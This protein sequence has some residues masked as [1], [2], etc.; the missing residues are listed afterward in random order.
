MRYDMIVVGAGPAGMTAALYGARAGKHV[1]LLEALTAGGQ[2]VDSQRIENYPALPDVDGYSFAQS[3]YDQV[4]AQGVRVE[5]GTVQAIEKR[6]DG[7]AVFVGETEYFAIS[8]ILATGLKHRRLGVTGEDR[9]VGRGVSF[10]ATCDGMFFRGR[11][12][13][14]IGGGNTAVQDAL[15]LSDFCSRVYLVHRRM[16][17]RA[18]QGLA[19]RLKQKNN[20]EFIGNTVVKEIRGEQTVSSLL[21]S[22]VATDKEREL[23]ISGI[24]E[25][26][27]QIPQNG[28][29][30]NVVALD[31]EGYFLVNDAMET[32]LEGVFAA[33]D[34]CRKT[35]RQLTTAVGDGTVAALSAAAY[36]DSVCAKEN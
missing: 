23:P 2:I 6:T 11:D 10:C 17:L 25:A 30:A 19:E 21:L 16:E 8:V 28:A 26:I 32:S 12:V 3:L 31:E 9:F 4:V 18:E 34:A 33:G 1:L 35:V 14:V 24:F 27:G 29:F 13:A 22:D 20:I 7:I 36:V 5:Y 15:V